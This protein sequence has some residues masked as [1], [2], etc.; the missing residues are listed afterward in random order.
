MRD[1]APPAADHAE[2]TVPDGACFV[3][4]DNRDSCKDSRSFGP[5]PLADLIGR[6]AYTFWPATTWR[7]FGA[8]R[9]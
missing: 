8:C 7:R 3:L 4:G 1:G 9:D 6:V 2:T 5:V